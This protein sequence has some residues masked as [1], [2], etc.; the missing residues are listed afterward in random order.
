MRSAVVLPQPDGA[1]QHQELAVL[2]FE[3][4]ALDDLH[5]R[6]RTCGCSSSVTRI[7]V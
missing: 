2:D 3:V 4:E 1:E 7:G 5:R 6:R